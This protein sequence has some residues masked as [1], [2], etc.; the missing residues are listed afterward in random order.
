MAKYKTGD[1]KS[2]IPTVI[3]VLVV[4]SLAIAT[5]IYSLITGTE[6]PILEDAF[7]EETGNGVNPGS[8]S[9]FPSAAPDVAAPAFPPPG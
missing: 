6:K 1:E 2:Y 9:P 5:F 3:A 8:N 7:I 4:I